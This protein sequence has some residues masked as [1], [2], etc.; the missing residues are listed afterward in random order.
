MNTNLIDYSLLIGEICEDVEII[1]QKVAEDPELSQGLYF[2][3]D[4]KA[5]V[6]GIIDPLTGFTFRKKAEY[7]F[8]RMKDGDK[9]SCVPP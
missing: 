7:T 6:I 8:K 3:K 4:G 1:K 2:S 9:M 5:Y